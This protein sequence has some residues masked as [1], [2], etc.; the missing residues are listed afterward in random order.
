MPYLL[1]SARCASWITR[2]FSSVL[3]TVVHVAGVACRTFGETQFSSVTLAWSAGP[4][5]RSVS[6]NRTCARV[7]L[8][9]ET[10]QWLEMLPRPRRFSG[11]LEDADHVRR[12]MRVTKTATAEL[13][14]QEV[15][16]QRFFASLPEPTRA[17]V[18]ALA[19][20]STR[21]LVESVEMLVGGSPAA[22]RPRDLQAARGRPHAPVR[23]RSRE[24]ATGG[25]R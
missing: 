3:V 11:A 14:I 2:C 1:P 8:S 13:Y 15:G 6:A 12:R 18:L 22:F 16:G 5:A 19:R 9:D 24:R 20:H 4:F 7:E 10:M 21:L 17:R 25:A 23:R